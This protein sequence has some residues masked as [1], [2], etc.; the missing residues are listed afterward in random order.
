MKIYL[1]SGNEHKKDEFVQIL[2][3]IDIVLP[4]QENIEF[5][6]EE[7]GTSF[8]ENAMLKARFLYKTV[9]QPVIADDSG[10]CIDYLNGMPGIYSARYGDEN[11]CVLSFDQKINKVLTELKNVQ[12][13]KAYFVCC[14]V[15]L[16]NE[17]RF[18]AVQEICEGYISKK[19]AG[20]NGFGYDPIFYVKEFGKTFA[21]LSED[22]KNKISHRGKAL[23][24]LKKIISGI[25]NF[26]T[27]Q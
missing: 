26:T 9:K 10:L 16:L 18:Y 19:A 22:E 7:T 27:N 15:L 1:A 12:N 4:K 8:F 23:F 24:S 20:T 11:G 6:P 17:H 25:N 2:S 3:G 5:D 13:R 14:I 21:E